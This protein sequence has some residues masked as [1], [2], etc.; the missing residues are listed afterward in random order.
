MALT[1]KPISTI[2]YNT[3]QFIERKLEQ[4]YKAKI[5]VDYRWIKHFG[6]DGDKDH[7]HL[8][9]FPNKRVDTGELQEEFKEVVPSEEKPLGVLPIRTSKE[10]HWL[11]Y[12]LHDE[13]YLKAHKSDNDGDGKIPYDITDIKTPFP[14]QLAR[15]YKKAI[16]LRKTKNQEIMDSLIKEHQSLTQ[17]MYNMNANPMQIIA[18]YQ[19]LLKEQEIERYNDSRVDALTEQLKKVYKAIEIQGTVKEIEELPQ[20]KVE[21]KMGVVSVH[22]KQLKMNYATGELEEEDKGI[23]QVKEEEVEEYPW[24]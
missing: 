23:K 19:A 6:E 16:A 12:V 17:T 11:M 1:A 2:S 15:D 21:E 22:E 18:I 5:I 9:M 8:I 3:E 14:E 10:D 13:D 20:L 24:D 4:L 7:I